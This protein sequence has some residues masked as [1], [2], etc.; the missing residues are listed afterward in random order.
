M[1]DEELVEYISNRKYK[2][3]LCYDLRQKVIRVWRRG[4]N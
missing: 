2:C 4:L 3:S 1:T